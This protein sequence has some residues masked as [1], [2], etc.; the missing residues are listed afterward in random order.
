MLRTWESEPESIE[1]NIALLKFAL[2]KVHEAA[3]LIDED[4]RIRYVNEESCRVLGYSREELLNLS[5]TD[6]DPDFPSER[7]PGHWDE[8]KERGSITFEGRHRTK[9]GRI[10]PVEISASYF[11]YD[12]QGYD[13]ALVRDITE[14]IRVE[15]ALRFIAQ[16]GWAGTADTFL[17]ALAGYLADTLGMDYVL[18]AH[19]LDDG[20]SEAETS[21]LHAKGEILSNVR[22]ELKGTPCENVIGKKLCIYPKG[23]QALF[24]ADTLLADMGAESYAGIPLWDSAGRPIGLLAALDGKPFHDENT[25]S[26]ILQLAATS[27]AAALER[28]R[29]DRLLAAREREFRTLAEN[30]P[31]CILRYDNGCRC[32]YANP[33]IENTLGIPAGGMIGKTP[34]DIF[35]AGEYRLYQERIEGVLGTGADADLEVV[36]PGTGEVGRHHH[37][38]FTAER[39]QEGAITGV[40][41]IGRDITERKQMENVLRESEERFRTLTEKSPAGIYIIQDD[42]FRY[43]NPAFAEIH[44]Y[45]P[46]EIINRL[47]PVDFITPEDRERVLYSIR[48]RTAGENMLS[49]LEFHIRRKDGS[50]RAVEVFGSRASHQG[51]PA[52][53]GT[54]IDVTERKKSEEK[55]FQ[56]TERWERTF[57]AVP[58]LIAII[59]ADCRIVQ[60]NKAMAERLGITP[61]E[62]EGQVCYEAIHKTEEPPSFCPHVQTLK[63]KHEHMTEVREAG[64]DGDF[65]VSTSP[66]FDSTGQLVGSVHVARDITERLK[67]EEERKMLEA[68]LHQA[69]KMEAIGQL[70]GGIAHDFNNI[71]TA[72]IG[73]SSIL[74]HRLEEENPLRRHA[75]QVLSAAERAAE[76]TN[77]LLAFSRRQVL[78]A[79]PVDLCEI[80]LGLEIML[81]RL[82]PEDIDFR[83]AVADGDLVVMADKVQIEQVLMNLVT[84]AKDAMPSG[85][86][87]TIE[88][89]PAL[90]EKQFVHAHGFGEPGDYA[91]ITVSDTGLGMDEE[92]QKRIFEPFFTTKEVGK[93]TGLGMAIIY[94]II[95]QHNGYISVYSEKERGTTFKVYLPL[96]AE[97]IMDLKEPMD[98][99][100]LPGGTETV[101]LAEDDAAVRELHRMM[102]EDA[103]YTVIKAVDGEDALKKFMERRTEV[104]I[105]ATDV[106]MPKVNGKALYEEIR[107]I[108]PDM[109]VLFMSGYTKDIIVERGIL[110]EEFSVL[111]KPITPHKLLRK[112]REILYEN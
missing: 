107:K 83:T 56:V 20:F 33:R 42:L 55:L 3:Y 63:D 24:P 65:I 16:R 13:L 21:A 15:D 32:I 77:C 89:F 103:G 108:R 74:I 1:K 9:D 69:Q 60:A 28:E 10:F 94:G 41:V 110:D 29:D 12:G 5:V 11:E 67:A 25:L 38:R 19:L 59:D 81:R 95:R 80:V 106:I 47:G 49:H 112:I 96:I 46:E 4:G 85:G 84:N 111:T 62:C 52:I 51:Y 64:L 2:D 98:A 72:I 36:I 23:V 78:N 6:I 90:M 82:V 39:D 100:P 76:L 58:D 40:L 27:A 99:E 104:D 26:Y 91:C 87:L 102:L 14:R 105:L 8:L 79:K 18:I 68:Q 101:L 43:V 22:Y 48:H 44:G 53:I 66:I 61:E 31:D 73:Y 86:A 35:P 7:W 50:I 70:A 88:I 71:L 97:E 54:I 57:N 93:G 92:T 37:V 34:M 109:K 75:K 45:T 17:S 30:S